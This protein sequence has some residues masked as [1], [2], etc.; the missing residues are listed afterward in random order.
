MFTSPS[1]TPE[2]VKRR[3]AGWRQVQ[4]FNHRA[5]EGFS[6]L[7]CECSITAMGT[8]LSLF[9]CVVLLCSH[10]TVCGKINY[11]F[12]I[13]VNLLNFV[14]PVNKEIDFKFFL[15][16]LFL[17]YNQVCLLFCFHSFLQ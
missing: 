4:Q 15:L 13:A 17:V 5:E 3:M 8:G 7:G 14:V 9:L 6:F 1:S 10:L 16:K 12:P 11:I 2:W